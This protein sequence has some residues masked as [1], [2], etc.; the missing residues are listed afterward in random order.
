MAT[1]KK[2]IIIIGICSLLIELVTSP[3]RAIDFKICGII[4][5]L[6]YFAFTIYCLR[7]YKNEIK[8]YPIFIAILTGYLVIQFPLRVLSWKASLVS[9]PD[10]TS[11]LLGIILGFI[12]FKT[13]SWIR[14]SSTAIGILF[15]L[16]LNTKGSDL[17]LNKLTFESFTGNIPSQP[18]PPGLIVTDRDNT[19]LYFNQTSE[20]FIVLDFWNSRCG[21]CFRE[22]PQVQALYEKYKHNPKFSLYAVNV[23][24]QQ[25]TTNQAY[26]IIRQQ[27]HTFPV[28]VYHTKDAANDP[29]LLSIGVQCVPTV[30]IVDRTGNFI[31][32]GDVKMASALLSK[33]LD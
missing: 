4:T 7:R 23:Q 19:S 12:Y 10:A 27:G 32:R 24:L 3:L 20:K 33:L 8:L 9:L 5:F 28:V 22:F 2:K 30:M 29:V 25:D 1:N 26:A 18:V 16:F 21:V 14:Y 15:C 31:F 13:K 11:H 17:W 6:L